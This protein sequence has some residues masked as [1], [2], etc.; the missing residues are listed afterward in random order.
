M[1]ALNKDPPSAEEAID[2]IVR[3]TEHFEGVTSIH[4]SMI[5]GITDSVPISASEIATMRYMAN[6][7]AINL[8]K[9]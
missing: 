8:S 4:P 2:A 9:A 3:S 6:S 1:G 7:C 5:E